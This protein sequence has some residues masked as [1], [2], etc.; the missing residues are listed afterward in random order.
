MQ[1][2]VEVKLRINHNT[3]E[4]FEV[5]FWGIGQRLPINKIKSKNK[6][7]AKFHFILNR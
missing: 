2:L 5:R 6:R 1:I 7:N 3:G 4:K